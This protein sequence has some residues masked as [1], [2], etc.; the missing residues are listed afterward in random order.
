MPPI[1]LKD[2][3]ERCKSVLRG[4]PV[5]QESFPAWRRGLWTA[6]LRAGSPAKTQKVF[7]LRTFARAQKH[8]GVYTMPLEIIV[9]H[10]EFL[11]SSNHNGS[12]T[13]WFL[14]TCIS[15]ESS[16]FVI[17]RQACLRFNSSHFGSTTYQLHH[18]SYIIFGTHT[19]ISLFLSSSL[20]LSCCTV[21]S[22]MADN[23]SKYIHHIWDTLC[24][25][26]PNTVEPGERKKK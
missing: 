11:R 3:K 2:V 4:V 23:K 21:P 10:K 16:H 9:E 18:T 20:P 12:R 1:E 13:T 7:K 5:F 8:T 19:H 24:K 14:F 25:T 22:F 26:P 6:A 17:E 15:D